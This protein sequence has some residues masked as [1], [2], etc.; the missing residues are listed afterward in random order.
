MTAPDTTTATSL[1]KR[2]STALRVLQ[3]RAVIPITT[4]GFQLARP[5]APGATP[6]LNG[7]A[8]VRTANPQEYKPD[9]ATI[10]AR[11]FNGH[12]VVHACIRAIADIAASI[13]FVVLRE[14]GDYESRVGEKHPLQQ[15]LDTPGPRLSARGLR[16]RLSVDLLGYGNAIVQME[17]TAPGGRIISLRPIN[18]ESLMTVWVDAEG[19]ARRYDYGNWSGIVVNV[20]AQDV[21]HVRDLEM[22]VPFQPDVFG[23]P[24]GATAITSIV[25][26]R[27]ATD[28]V[29]QIVTNDG[30]PT[31]AV[32]LSEEA[33]QEDAM[34]MQERYR[35]R[36]VDRGKR[37]TPAFFSQ[38]KD[39]KPLGFT[40]AD[41]EFPDLRRVSR[42]DICA[43]FGVDP[44]MIGVGSATKDG[45]LSGV[46]YRE[47]RARLVQ[48]TIEPLMDAILDEI[49]FW[50]APEFGDVYVTYDHDILRDLV[51]DDD[52]TSTR[53]R[54][55][56][57]ASLRTWEEAR[58]ALRL[59]PLPEP[60]DTLLMSTGTQL[61]PAAVAVIDPR[62]VVDEPPATDSAQPTTTGDAPM[63]AAGSA[64]VQ[65]TA[66]NGAQVT[67]LIEVLAQVAGKALP[68]QTAEALLLAAFPGV[69]ESLVKQMLAGLSSF[70]P[71]APPTPTPAPAPAA[72]A[73][74][75]TDFP[76]KGDNKTISLRNSGYKLF[77]VAEAEA[78]KAD[79]PSVW[80]KGGNI[81]GNQQFAL[82]APIAKRG[83]KADGEAEENAIKRRE[84]WAA[85]HEGNTELPGI[86][87]Q[88]KWLVVAS[89]GLPH[90]RK[91]LRE[92]KAKADARREIV[93]THTRA[94]ADTA[95][96]GEQVGALTELLE[97]VVEGELPAEAVKALIA[98]AFPTIRPAL[99]DAM[100]AALD[101]FTPAEEEDEEDEDEEEDGA[102]EVETASAMVA[103]PMAAEADGPA[104]DWLRV[105]EQL[106]SQPI[107]DQR[108]DPKYAIWKRAQDEL[109]VREDK[110][111]RTA[112]RQFV[113]DRGDFTRTFDEVM[114]TRAADNAIDPKKAREV[115]RKVRESRK[116]GGR[117]YE[118]WKRAYEKLVGD[119][120]VVGASQVTGSVAL[121]FAVDSP[122]VLRAI[123]R[124]TTRLAELIGDTTANQ[125]T[126]AIRA[127]EKA[128][129]TVAETKRLVQASVYG[130]QMSDTRAL[131]IAKTEAAGA[132]SQG[133]WDQAKSRGDLYRSKEWL[134]FEDDRTRM[135]HLFCMAQGS[136]PIDDE[137]SNGLLYPLDP[138]GDA[139][140]VINCRCVLTYSDEEA[141]E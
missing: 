101:G 61:T 140:E 134:A 28:Y 69:P 67:A 34:A 9:G 123:E 102:E 37:G 86:V 132:L 49:N 50:L 22:P 46:Q 127:A 63:V 19:D 78:L 128:S 32:M 98:A 82:L 133:S 39:I 104:P 99:V 116:K 125:V 72:R 41:L 53:V 45:G 31:F 74:K 38:V 137:F 85:R 93:A 68:A 126:A 90:M 119:T 107:D 106:Q 92:A 16:T 52:A 131:R 88:V 64:D 135:T 55:E 129:M 130:E 3:G 33:M 115:E 51:E 17:R 23:F 87:A 112:R 122:E 110:F 24:R 109:D 10:R 14:R 2:L 30:T 138:N 84:A 117:T 47:A 40:L 81:R 26:D 76:T 94:M 113:S 5:T 75:V 59:S 4:P 7:M 54:A 36:V 21:L 1:R 27:E 6:G 124:R 97:M 91:V 44:R 25:A 12:P 120:Y 65:A 15:L 57:A 79:Y 95:L 60:T 11:G 100:L 71:P 136:I 70:T 29:R 96:N 139:G 48:H 118:S 77:P 42:E 80:R 103:P 114:G 83:G 13:P 8:L 121:S 141:P 20:D 58:R 62:A 89:A 35:A 111:Y 108:A 105:A 43:A 73:E 18:P 66:L 56:V